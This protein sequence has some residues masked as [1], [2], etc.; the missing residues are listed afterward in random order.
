LTCG[1]D[2]VPFV[3]VPGAF[4]G[5]QVA[6][7]FQNR[8]RTG[9]P[10]SVAFQWL[11]SGAAV[12]E[13]FELEIFSMTALGASARERGT[14]VLWVSLVCP[15]VSKL[16]YPLMSMAVLFGNTSSSGLI[17]VPASLPGG[18]GEE[19]PSSGA[20]AVCVLSA[21]RANARVSVSVPGLGWSNR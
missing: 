18:Q 20:G 4:C 7:A 5:G 10:W 14:A 21:T 6:T 12:I 11:M 9:S 3:V 17:A 15:P 2:T 16:A 1:R 19:T 8:L 13:N